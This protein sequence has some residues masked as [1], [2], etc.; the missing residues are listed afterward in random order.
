[1]ARRW[2]LV[3]LL[4][5]A[6]P[7]WTSPSTCEESDARL[8][9]L[10]ELI[11][12]SLTQDETDWC[13]TSF[14][15][16]SHASKDWPSQA[17]YMHRLLLALEDPATCLN[18]SVALDTTRWLNSSQAAP[19]ISGTFAW[20][21]LVFQVQYY[22]MPR[23]PGARIESPAT[24]GRKCWAF[25]YL[26]DFWDP[27]ALTSSLATADLDVSGFVD[28]HSAAI[29]LTMNLCWEVMSNC[30]VNASYDP[31]RNGT[32]PG[33]IDE[34]RFGFDRENIKRGRNVEYPFF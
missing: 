29:P 33:K 32:C 5:S 24:L 21:Y 8:Q 17:V 14:E 7:A 18:T 12:D 27:E 26:S 22:D 30:F 3:A 16:V 1:M 10:Q 25:A 4:A 19:D 6:T 20:T 23:Q 28:M 13:G 15:N 31:S 9:F 11:C 34:F 2:L